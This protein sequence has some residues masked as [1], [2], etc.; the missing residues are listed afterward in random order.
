MVTISDARIDRI[1]AEDIPYL[2]L[3]TH[4]LGIADAPG[5]MEYF[6]REACVLAGTEVA[7]RVAERI[8][9]TVVESLPSGT[10]LEAGQTFM[11][12]R[13]TAPQ[14]HQA[15][16]VCLN[17]FDHLSAVASATR[18]MVSAAHDANPA[19]EVLTTRKSMP[20][21]KDLLVE[22]TI[23]GGAFPH[24]LGLS[25]TILVFDHHLAFMGG[26]EKFL[27]QLPSIR[28]RCV[29]KKLF[30]EVNAAQALELAWYNAASARACAAS[31][32]AAPW[33]GV[34]GVQVD[35]L[36]VPE[37]ANLVGQLRAL[38]P[39]MAIIAAGGINA[40][41]AAEYAATGVDGL[42]T[43]APFTAKPIDMSVRMR[44]V[45]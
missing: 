19:C 30:V 17:L 31:G 29:E 43:T 28:P 20:G 18:A 26:F 13:G 24:R 36:A 15:W 42:A 2:D 12:V 16:K 9:C 21:V 33:T 32:G 37:L 44:G 4:V 22:A 10:E 35:K 45:E 11:T 38:D 41:N 1:I 8:G 6:T 14:L 3:T 27:E 5:E 34:D 40:A 7:S 39:R 23:A 25:E